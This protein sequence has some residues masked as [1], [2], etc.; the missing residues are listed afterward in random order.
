M[1][2]APDAAGAAPALYPALRAEVERC[3][4]RN[5]LTYQGIENALK[6]LLIGSVFEG[7]Q[8]DIAGRMAARAAKVL[9]MTL[10]EAS[11]GAFDEVLTATP[12]ERPV[13]VDPQ[14]LWMR[15]RLRIKPRPDQ[16]DQFLKMRLRCEAIVDQRN[17]LVHQFLRQWGRDTDDA[18]R[19]IR[20]TLDSQHREAAALRDELAELLQKLDAQQDALAAYLGSSEGRAEIR[21]KIERERD[22]QR[23]TIAGD[24]AGAGRGID[25]SV[26]MAQG[27]VINILSETAQRHQ[28]AYG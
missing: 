4:G 13:E 5:L 23:K 16:P 21:S 3:V 25:V 12:R 6:A 14:K 19:T 18:L 7:T 11:R 10:G 8:D 28:R 22:T 27:N 17:D 1:A 2:D 20:E 9:R 24:F 15:F 26:A